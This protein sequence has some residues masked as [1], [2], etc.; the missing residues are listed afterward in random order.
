M[1]IYVAIKRRLVHWAIQRRQQTSEDYFVVTAVHPTFS[2]NIK[3]KSYAFLK[4]WNGR[5]ALT[6]YV[7]AWV[8]VNMSKVGSVF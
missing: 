1:P 2:A 5:H 8:V 4:T 6:V 3:F 7:G